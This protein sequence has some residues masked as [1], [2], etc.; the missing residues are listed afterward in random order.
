MN[1]NQIMMTTNHLIFGGLLLSSITGKSLKDYYFCIDIP[2][3]YIHK[4]GKNMSLL[5]QK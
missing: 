3:L 5:E 1:T 2:D 4:N